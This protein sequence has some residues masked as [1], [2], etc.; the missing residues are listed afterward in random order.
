MTTMQKDSSNLAESESPGNTKADMFPCGTKSIIAHGKLS[1]TGKTLRREKGMQSS[2]PSISP[3]RTG[4][5][6]P[7]PMTYL[8]AC[9]SP[10]AAHTKIFV[11]KWACPSMT[12]KRGNTIWIH[13]A[14]TRARA[15]STQTLKPS[16]P[17]RGNGKSWKRFIEP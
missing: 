7:P 17:G 3:M 13:I 11:W 14:S 6:R 15:M 10:I 2:S 8:L 16:S 5:R 12:R 4:T 9:V 1:Y